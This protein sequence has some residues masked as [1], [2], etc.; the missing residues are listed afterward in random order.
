MPKS[1]IEKKIILRGIEIAYCLKTSIRARKL[2]IIIK[3]GGIVAA[4][5]PRFLSDR[6]VENFLFEKADWVLCQID[7]LK[8]RQGLMSTG[9]KKDFKRYSPVAR[10]LVLEKIAKFNQ[11]YK[12]SFNRVVVRNQAT[13]WGSCSRKKNL[14]FNYRIALLPERLSDYIVVHEMCHLRELNHSRNFWDLV[15]IAVPDYASCRRELKN[16]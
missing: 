6:A 9:T 7:R 12:V 11:I 10:K 3:P 13:R 14:N 4:V 5:K 2:R 1:A 8:D 15:A 16:F